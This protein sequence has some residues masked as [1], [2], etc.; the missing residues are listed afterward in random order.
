MSIHNTK[1]V[2]PK[3]LAQAL[4]ES[5]MQH[6][7]TGGQVNTMDTRQYNQNGAI[8]RG[9]GPQQTTSGQ[10]GFQSNGQGFNP[11]P[12]SQSGLNTAGGYGEALYGNPQPM[13]SQ[14]GNSGGQA[15]N[16]L[17][18]MMQNAAG[19]FTAQNQ[20]QASAPTIQT[21]NFS[22]GIGQL[23]NQQS[24]VYGQQANLANALLAQSQGQGPNPAQ[25]QLAQNTGQNVANQAALM[26][27]QRGAN[28]NPALLARQAAMQGA[29]TQQQAVGQ[30]ATLGA[31]Q[32]LSA[33]QALAQQQNSMQNQNLQGQSILQGG[34]A[35]QNTAVTTG[36]LGAQNINANIAGQNASAING[37]SGG[38]SNALGA[39]LSSMLYK[40][41]KVQKF[42]T[43][44]IAQYA[45]PQSS[46]I[47]MNSSI[48]KGIQYTGKSS[49]IDED[50]LSD[51]SDKVQGYDDG[52][53]VE[54]LMGIENFTP[55]SSGSP[56]GPAPVASPGV[57]AASK[58][59]G[60]GG[61]LAGLAALLARGGSVPG[62]A[63]VKGNSPKNDVVPAELSPGEIVL[64]RSVTQAKDPEK[65]AVEFL[66]HLKGAK[67]PDYKDVADSKKS[68]KDRVEALERC[69]GGRV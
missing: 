30:A 24:D 49:A 58:G 22:A 39:G 41:G 61:G 17:G 26:A 57:S 68:L 25:A 5:S 2:M 54:P 14:L 56:S 42:D 3:K 34:Q 50:G 12:T 37:T 66:R 47:Q 31:Q 19:A 8:P 52:G 44:G 4:M 46:P 43:G 23:E 65:K 36:Q 10:G 64:P 21:Q 28:A 9:L 6:F 35:A 18:G 67:K 62:Q 11:I 7:D 29:N 63:A 20:Y 16:G 32:Q 13:M 33:Q 60:G 27:S 51:L 1:T 38:I 59:G 55:Q 69:M 45:A 15:I 53:D 48:N 40:G